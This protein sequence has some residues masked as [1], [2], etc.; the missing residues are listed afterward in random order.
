[1][2]DTIDAV[3]WDF[4]GVISSTFLSLFV[5]PIVYLAL[6]RLKSLVARFWPGAKAGAVAAA[7]YSLSR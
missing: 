5:V 2:S 1:M 7:A 4:G 3:I 6:E